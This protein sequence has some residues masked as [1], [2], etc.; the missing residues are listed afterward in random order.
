[1]IYITG[2]TH[3]E[4]M[5]RLRKDSFPEQ[6]D[7]TTDDL[8]IIAG[9][10][11]LWHDNATERYNLDWLDG[12]SFTT[13]FVDGNHENFDRL[14]SFPVSEWNGGKVHK[15]RPSVIHLMRGQ[16]FTLQEKT[17]FTFGGASSHDIK[18]GILERDDPRIRQYAE[19]YKAFRINHLSWWEQELPSDEEMAEGLKNLE[20]HGNKVDYIITHSPDTLMLRQMDRGSR[21]YKR[22]RLTDYLLQVRQKVDFKQWIFGHMH[23]DA[24]FCHDRS[25]CLYEQ[26]VRLL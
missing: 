21:Y 14:Y 20:E 11:G 8:V 15:I 22:D 1:M 26:I 17:F 18:D 6:E 13:L 4:W 5:T 2:D 3:G 12:R 10:F 25:V 19:E 16:V 24:N 7:M 9:D 23:R